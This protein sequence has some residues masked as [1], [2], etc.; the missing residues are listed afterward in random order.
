MSHSSN[1]STFVGFNAFQNASTTTASFHHQ[2][3][4]NNIN[5]NNTNT[6]TNTNKR[7]LIK[8]TPVFLGQDAILNQSFHWLNKKSDVATRSRAM[9]TIRHRAFVS[10]LSSKKKSKR[11]EGLASFNHVLFIM[12]KLCMDNQRLVRLGCLQMLLDASVA[13]PKAWKEFVMLGDD[14]SGGGRHGLE[15]SYARIYV[16]QVDPSKDVRQE[17]SRLIQR[18]DSVYD[19]SKELRRSDQ[20][21]QYL[22]FMLE[23]YGRPINLSDLHRWRDGDPDVANEERFERVILCILNSYEKCVSNLS[24]EDVSNVKVKLA[25]K[26]LQSSRA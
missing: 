11:V 20:I 1:G 2:S 19:D 21:F 13:L 26:H 25:L 6:N 23:T 24:A 4:P 14:D 17:A 3:S 16:L 15:H 8:P 5:N 22:N 18:F 7:C 12:E 9:E 10:S